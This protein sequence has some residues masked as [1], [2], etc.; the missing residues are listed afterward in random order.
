MRDAKIITLYKNKG[1]RSD[2]NNHREIFLLDIASKAFARVMLPFLQKLTE[3]V[4]PE[5]QCGFTSKLSDSS[6]SDMIFSVR[7]LQE[8]SKE[9]KVPLFIAFID[10]TKA[11]NVVSTE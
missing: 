2:C 4:Y 5:L 10:L 6:I 9:Q 7:Q 3:R 11:F 8:K 1:A